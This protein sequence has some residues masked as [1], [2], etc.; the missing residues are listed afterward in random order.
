MALAYIICGGTGGHLAPG[1]AFAQ[2]WREHGHQCR[3]VVSKKDVDVRLSRQHPDLEFLQA[4]GRAFKA[5]PA[6]MLCWAWEIVASLAMAQRHLARERPDL[7]ISFG[8]F[9]GFPW[10][11]I[12]HMHGLPVFLHEAN[13]VPGRATR[14][15]S[16]FAC[17]VYLPPG[18]R[19]ARLP[20]S[21]VRPI[22]LPLRHEVRHVRKADIRAQWGIPIGTKVLLVMGGSQGATALNEWVDKNREAL[23][24]EGIWVYCLTGPGKASAHVAE[25]AS[26]HG[27]P[28]RFEWIPF[29]DKMG[30]LLSLADV[31]IC[32]SGAGA[33]AELTRC[34]TPAILVPYP[35]A[36]DNHQMANAR[37]LEQRGGGVVV[38]QEQI[39]TLLS[40]TIE[41]IFNDWLLGRMREN[42]RLLAHEDAAESLVQ[43]IESILTYRETIAAEHLSRTS[44]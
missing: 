4:P 33:I 32:R 34:L 18:V 7:V 3:L 20:Q 6:G 40:E 15:L 39:D 12:A 30:E 24:S 38:P 42:L 31:V 21:L 44:S 43:D 13:R 9:M 1:I 41:L 16:T 29:T 14:W 35:H 11:M 23:V 17:R 27:F 5:N 10:A 37:Y 19:H 2:R 25:Y 8:G 36:A 22:G 26:R 28:V